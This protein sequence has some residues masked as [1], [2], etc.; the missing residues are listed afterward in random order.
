MPHHKTWKAL[1]RWGLSLAVL[2]LS[3]WLALRLT[4]WGAFVEELARVPLARLWVLL[5]VILAA[6]LLRAWRWRLMLRA[7]LERP[8]KLGNAFSAVMIGY[9]VNALLPRA[10][11]LVRPYILSRRERMPLAML[12]SSVIA[13]RLVD[14]MTLVA[15]LLAGGI[16]F[17][18]QAFAV[19]GVDGIRAVVSVAVTF[20][21]VVVLVMAL[22]SARRWGG[23]LLRWLR[24]RAPEMAQRGVRVL[25]EL[26][27]GV[28]SL[29][30][31][32]FFAPMVA[33]TLAMWFC[34][35]LPL[36]GL[37]WV[38]SLPLGPAAA[39]QVLVVSAVAISV[40]P[41]PSAAGVYHVAVQ[42]TLVELFA[43]PSA[44]ALV[45]AV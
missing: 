11:E 21:V 19:V 8:P 33:L 27:A 38:C 45:Y 39:F 28:L 5:P 3:F 13:E 35:W 36:Y 4:D 14:V 7:A 23:W 10:G 22:A 15:L 12:L 6:H 34:Y 41:T 2:V 31:L 24:Q 16:A 42:L 30:R 37:F 44:E 25:E 1:L 20:A 17:A 18:E 9:A 26:R 40:A 43:V 29:R 32:R